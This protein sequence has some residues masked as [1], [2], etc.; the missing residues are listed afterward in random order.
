MRVCTA[1]SNSGTEQFTGIDRLP[2]NHVD[3]V[4]E[5]RATFADGQDLV[6]VHKLD[7]DDRHTRPLD[8]TATPG[9]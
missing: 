7:R 8:S 2:E 6:G 5:L 9:R 3:G 4:P 1:S